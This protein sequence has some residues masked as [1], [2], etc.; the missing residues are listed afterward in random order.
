MMISVVEN[1]RKSFDVE[2][3]KKKFDF[4]TELS[5]LKK[6]LADTK[7]EAVVSVSTSRKVPE[8]ATEMIPGS[9]IISETATLGTTEDSPMMEEIKLDGAEKSAESRVR[10]SSFAH[11][12]LKSKLE[13]VEDLEQLMGLIEKYQSFFN[14]KYDDAKQDY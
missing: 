6:F 3:E 12:Y 10:R 5:E 2:V 11:D 4:E 14:G 1:Y 9:E 8:M 13:T 7:S